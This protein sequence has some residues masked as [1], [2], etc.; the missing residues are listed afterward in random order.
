MGFVPDYV[1]INFKNKR[2]KNEIFDAVLKKKKKLEK[3]RKR[4]RKL[5]D[6]ERKNEKE[7]KKEYREG[8][9]CC[10]GGRRTRGIGFC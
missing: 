6:E 9:L 10:N 5:K 3:E 7:E 2:E 8:S 1:C 4:K